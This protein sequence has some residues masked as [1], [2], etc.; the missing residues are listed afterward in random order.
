MRLY[1]L[2]PDGSR[3]RATGAPDQISS[4][5]AARKIASNSLPYQRVIVL[6]QP[7]VALHDASRRKALH[8]ASGW[9]L[10]LERVHSGAC[11]VR[12]MEAPSRLM[13]TSLR[14]HLYRRSRRE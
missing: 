1:A 13:P 4:T 9:G 5:S 11:N 6:P 8:Q 7:L 3:P 2:A 10:A 14:L 12:S